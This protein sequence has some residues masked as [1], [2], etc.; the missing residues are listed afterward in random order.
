MGRPKSVQDNEIPQ[1]DANLGEI[2]AKSEVSADVPRE[3]RT[4]LDARAEAER[5][6]NSRGP[7]TGV[8]MRL[9]FFG[10]NPGWQR[11]WVTGANVPLRLRDGYRFVLK[12]EVQ[13]SNSVNLG[14]TSTDDR[15][16]HPAGGLDPHGGPMLLYLM[17][18]PVE[19][20]KEL[21]EVR[22]DA[23]ARRLEEAIK[24]GS[25]HGFGARTY[26]PDW[27]TNKVEQGLLSET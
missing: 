8:E 16:I 5:I 2:A 24:S 7:L 27:A 22:R 26:K 3:T 23:P 18:I 19:I 9:E 4:R 21:D 10:T 14:N 1:S 15:V 25:D 13:M 12:D 11:R 20:A 6:R 17:E